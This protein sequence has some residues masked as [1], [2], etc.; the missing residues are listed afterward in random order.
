[1]QRR[2]R[3]MVAR[4]AIYLR[5]S[6]D[7]QTTECQR[8]EVMQIAAARNFDVVQVYEE[9]ASAV[10]H[11]PDVR[12]DAQGRP[13][14]E[15]RRTHHLVARPFRQ[16]DGWQSP[17][18]CWNWTGWA[19]GVSVRE[20]WLDTGSPVRSL[21]NRDLLL[22]GRAGTDR[23]IERT[24]AGLAAARRR[25][26]KIGRPRRRSI[27]S[28]RG[29][30]VPR[31]KTSGRSPGTW[32]WVTRPSAGLSPARADAAASRPSTGGAA[33]AGDASAVIRNRLSGRLRAAVD[34]A[35]LSAGARFRRPE[36]GRL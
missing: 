7:R 19:S 23:L 29:S 9:Q 13:A 32:A 24:K 14:R 30:F 18:T 33:A 21:S 25:G 27:S 20:S 8:P 3:C 16:V 17:A 4:V 2:S 11:R 26:A 10:K 31:D 36:S 34:F 5:V 28:G 22:G 15:V 12:A 6:T 35:M 1:M